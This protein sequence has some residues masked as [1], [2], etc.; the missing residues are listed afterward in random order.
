MPMGL[1]S[2]WARDYPRTSLIALHTA[3]RLLLLFIA[4]A[5]PGPGYDTSTN[6]LHAQQNVYGESS[7]LGW[8]PAW[9]SLSKL[10]RWDSIYFT[11]IGQRGYLW[12]QEWAFGWGFTR[13]LGAI[14]KGDSFP[15]LQ[16]QFLLMPLVLSYTKH[17]DIRSQETL[18]G[19]I[20]SHASHLLSVLVLH[21]LT[22]AVYS[23]ATTRKRRQVALLSATLHIISPAG[24][25]L[26]APSPESSFSL[27]N[28]TGF[29]LY[30]V[31]LTQ[32]PLR[33]PHLN[34]CLVVLS[35]VLLGIATTFRGN[36]LLSG[37]V[38]VYDATTSLIKVMQ[39]IEFARSSQRLV[40]TCFS[41]ISMACV[42]LVPQYLAYVEYCM[43]LDGQRR[44]WCIGWT[45]SIYAWVQ[46][47]YW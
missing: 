26:C 43:I 6:L 23:K 2:R 39:G 12:E 29:Y 9:S 8:T 5:S 35:G 24:M 1:S 45:P 32:H 21:E 18:A 22:L 25:F 41:G 27:L 40:V 44:P 37:L 3:W 13:S 19:L 16:D 7:D 30:A 10:V 28:F 38:L 17:V 33:S 34:N 15:F 42:A 36:G 47:E 20:I 46:K 31:S 11:Q 4:L 14:G